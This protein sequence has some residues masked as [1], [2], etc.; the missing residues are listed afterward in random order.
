MKIQLTYDRAAHVQT[1]LLVIILDSTITLHNLGGG[2]IGEIVN[3]V[4]KDF[5]NKRLKTDYFSAVES[6]DT[7]G[8]PRHILITSTSLSPNF[9]IWEN[10]KIAVA[11]A[12]RVA[13]DHGLGGVAVA[14]NTND[15]APFIGKAVEGAIIG[16]YA[17][18]RYRSEKSTLSKVD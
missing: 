12:I 18:D 3:R 13:R 4:K 15:A 6:R 16:S 8:G 17:F 2:P 5:T 11:R 9:N 10:V 14:L 1:D 7:K